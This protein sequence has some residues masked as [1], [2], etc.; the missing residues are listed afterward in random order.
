MAEQ[1]MNC[2]LEVKGTL[3]GIKTTMCGGYANDGFLLS[4]NF[5]IDR[6]GLCALV[7]TLGSVCEDAVEPFVEMLGDFS[8]EVKLNYSDEQTLVVINS[9]SLKFVGYDGE[10]KLVVFNIA[11]AEMIAGK[12]NSLAQIVKKAV[13][14]FGIKDFTFLYRSNNITSNNLYKAFGYLPQI[15]YVIKDS[16]V[17]CGRFDFSSVSKSMFTKA[18][19]ELFGINQMGVYLGAGSSNVSCALVVPD[20]ENSILKC[21]NIILYA[22][23]GSKGVRFSMEGSIALSCFSGMEFYVKCELSMTSVSISACS[24]PTNT[25]TIPK[26]PLTI[27]NSGL[28]IGFDEK[29]LNFAIMTQIN[30][31]SLMWYG[32]LRMSY[33]G[34]TVMLDMLS[35]AM[36][37]VS[38]AALAENLIGLPRD[39][40]SA[41]D[42]IAVRTFNLN[43]S[44]A[45]TKIDFKNKTDNQIIELIN[46]ALKGMKKESVIRKR[47]K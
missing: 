35:M 16:V 1:G 47:C 23:F 6:E 38:L 9:D 7:K 28:Q 22:Q 42:I 4:S 19:T 31:R 33:Q 20:M 5:I 21:R 46:T 40:V 24:M 15:P 17:I 39:K 3:C 34:T 44:Q 26:T 32:A 14:Y 27:C 41:L 18:M 25:Y 13:Y 43:T 30:I 12:N 45:D 11:P 10:G 37:E 8:T 29:G 2:I 36:S